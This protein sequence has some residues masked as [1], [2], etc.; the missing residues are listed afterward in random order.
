MN[1]HTP[2]D[3]IACL[4]S[5][6]LPVTQQRIEIA[7]ILFAQPVHLTADQVLERVRVHAP[8]T[9]RATVYNTLR[10][11][12]EKKL[13]REL[14]VDRDRAVFDSNASAHHHLYDVDTGQVSD[15]PGD[16][17]QVMGVPLLPPGFELEA[18][19]LIVRVR[20]ARSSSPP[21]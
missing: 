5:V 14:I 20:S 9:S 13:V 12:C 10:L 2:A 8:D 4:R 11:F 15:L 3:A 21:D 7:R 17:L 1:I 19:D 6:G 18:I 16:A